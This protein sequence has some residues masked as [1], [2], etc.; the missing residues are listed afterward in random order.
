MF[1]NLASCPP[2]WSELTAARGRY[3]VGLPAGGTPAAAVGVAL[4]DQESRAVGQ[5]GHGITDPGHVHTDPKRYGNGG[6]T[7]TAVWQ[8][9]G[10]WAGVNPTATGITINSSGAVAGPSAPYIQLLFCQK[11]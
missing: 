1:F 3:P 7:H 2:G 5:H 9:S 10:N 8:S 6:G 4:S 11:D